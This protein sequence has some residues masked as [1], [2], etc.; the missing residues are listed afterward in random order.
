MVNAM[1][2]LAQEFCGPVPDV[3]TRAGCGRTVLVIEDDRFVREAA[4]EVL[5]E[6]GFDVIAAESAAGA[7]SCCF[8]DAE[9]VDAVLCDAMLP[10][11]SGVELCRRLAAE[12]PALRVVLASGYPLQHFASTFEEEFHFRSKPYCGELLM[13]AL[14]F[15]LTNEPQTDERLRPH[16]IAESL[17]NVPG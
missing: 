9:R 16:T 8:F 12:N 5:R 11:G 17:Q 10:D 2:T 14:R 13:A 15:V 3:Q 1:A 7:Q 4:C 6:S